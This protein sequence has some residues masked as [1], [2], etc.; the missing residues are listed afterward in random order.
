MHPSLQTYTHTLAAQPEANTHICLPTHGMTRAHA[1][2]TNRSAGNSPL[3]R[4]A[5]SRRSEESKDEEQH[6]GELMG[7]WLSGLPP[8]MPFHRGQVKLKTAP[9]PYPGD[10]SCL[11][12]VT[13]ALRQGDPKGRWEHIF[14]TELIHIDAHTHTHKR[15]HTQTHAYTHTLA[16]MHTGA[17]HS[18]ITVQAKREQQVSAQEWAHDIKAQNQNRHDST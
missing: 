1:H 2:Y 14:E 3:N 10:L 11:S 17:H 15:T 13:I 18:A 12:H 6:T 4:R 5:N 16:C 9:C 8:T 7:E